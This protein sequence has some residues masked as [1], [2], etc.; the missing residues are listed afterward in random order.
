MP[1]MTLS[2]PDDLHALIKD[3]PEIN[4]SAVARRAL[5]E[6]A[7]KWAWLEDTLKDSKLTKK[8]V[9]ELDHLIKRSATERLK[10]EGL[11]PTPTSSSQPSSK[12]AS[13]GRS[14]ANSRKTSS[15]RRTS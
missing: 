14:S 9:E 15:S 5:K 3:H 11:W 7:E 8:D 12:K 4:W 6:H 2:I 1:N 13:R 10:K